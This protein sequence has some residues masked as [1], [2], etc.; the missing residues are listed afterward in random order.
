MKQKMTFWVLLLCLGLCCSCNGNA[1]QETNDEETIEIEREVTR[2]TS[3]ITIPETEPVVATSTVETVSED[4]NYD[5]NETYFVP[6]TQQTDPWEPGT[7][8]NVSQLVVPGHD[9]AE[10][11]VEITL[12][13]FTQD[14]EGVLWFWGDYF[15]ISYRDW[16][17][18]TLCEGPFV[19][20]GII[21]PG[22]QD[23]SF[24]TR[25][26]DMMLNK[27]CQDSDGIRVYVET[28]GIVDENG[29]YHGYVYFNPVIDNVLDGQVGWENYTD[30]I[31]LNEWLLAYGFAAPDRDYDGPY[32]EIYQQYPDFN[33]DFYG[34]PLLLPEYVS[35]SYYNFDFIFYDPSIP[36][37]AY[38]EY[39][40]YR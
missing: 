10:N 14:Y 7:I 15:E 24:L 4:T 34:Y 23:D 6:Y 36:D 37:E 35:N 9:F 20:D 5:P 28:D 21:L 27:L 32:A 18:D 19:L 13:V 31:Q 8:I 16:H 17:D 22:E 26:L 38:D 3:P 1:A 40:Y 39:G 25:G 33:E 30:L 11:R 2:I 29:A 12:D